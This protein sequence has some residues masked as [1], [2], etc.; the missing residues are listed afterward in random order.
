LQGRDWPG[1]ESSSNQEALHCIWST[2]PLQSFPLELPDGAA[3]T[4]CGTQRMKISSKLTYSYIKQTPKHKTHPAAGCGS[5]T[6]HLLSTQ[7]KEAGTAQAQTT[8]LVF[9]LVAGTAAI[10]PEGQTAN[11]EEEESFPGTLLAFELVARCVHPWLHQKG[12]RFR[13]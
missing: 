5:L 3:C 2:T 7:A 8:A 6:N 1:P 12:C 9:T 11:K 4:H 10:S 13:C